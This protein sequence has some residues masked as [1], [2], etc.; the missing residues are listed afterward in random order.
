[1]TSLADLEWR[2]MYP[3]DRFNFP[4]TSPIPNEIMRRAYN[5]DP[6]AI[7]LVLD[8]LPPRWRINWFTIKVKPHNWHVRTSRNGYKLAEIFTSPH[9]Y[10]N[11]LP[12]FRTQRAPI[13]VAP[14]QPTPDTQY[15]RLMPNETYEGQLYPE[16]IIN[17]LKNS[18]AFDGGRKMKKSSKK[19]KKSVKKS[20]KTTKKSKKHM[21]KH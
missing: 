7:Q 20:K 4:E 9:N 13:P 11:E 8:E 14:V 6:E 15:S 2:I 12:V 19:S 18:G 5:N 17:T 10:F 16:Q 21:K 1:M 3:I